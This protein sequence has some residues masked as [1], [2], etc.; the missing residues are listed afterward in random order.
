MIR[1]QEVKKFVLFQRGESSLILTISCR[2][3]FSVLTE[4]LSYRQLRPDLLS[5][6][7]E[8]PSLSSDSPQKCFLLSFIFYSQPL[9]S[10]FSTYPNTSEQKFSYPETEIFALADPFSQRD[11][12]NY[13]SS[14]KEKFDR[15]EMLYLRPLKNMGVFIMASG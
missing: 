11:V 8:S 6:L 15:K 12:P 10:A 5:H 7:P 1:K 13:L 2:S 3:K 14:G 4:V 9:F